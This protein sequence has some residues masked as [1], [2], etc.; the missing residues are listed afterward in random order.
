MIMK[1]PRLDALDYKILEHMSRNAREPLSTIAKGANVSL[2]TVSD[3]LQ[4]L[5][6]LGIIKGFRA[7]LNYD[8]VGLGFLAI[9]FVNS[10]YGHDYANRVAA[11]IA[12]IV[13]VQEIHFV[14]GDLDFIVTSRA[15]D[16]EDLKRIV[17]EFINIPEI[18]KTSTHIVLDTLK[19]SEGQPPDLRETKQSSKMARK[20]LITKESDAKH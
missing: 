19:E 4:R 13:G 16:R 2:P 20:T 8:A 9:T 17:N 3:R 1:N 15:R 10:K 12:K 18:E 11:K 7:E 6:R 14:M 5:V